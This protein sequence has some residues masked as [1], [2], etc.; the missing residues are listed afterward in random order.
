MC[1]RSMCV[2]ENVC[3]IQCTLIINSMADVAVVLMLDLCKQGLS[4]LTG[5]TM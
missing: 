4:S 1:M 2:Y 5:S 3:T